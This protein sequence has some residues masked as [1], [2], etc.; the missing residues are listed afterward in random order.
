[1]SYPTLDE[2]DELAYMLEEA[3]L[4]CEYLE[5]TYGKP[6]WASYKAR[7]MELLDNVEKDMEKA[8]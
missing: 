6:R 3:K 5:D 8:R 4:Q 1:M 7:I 2:L